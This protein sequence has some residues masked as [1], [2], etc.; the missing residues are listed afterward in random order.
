MN[1]DTVIIIA[2]SAIL[3][4]KETRPYQNLSLNYSVYLN[5]LLYS[6]WLEI[7]KDISE[8]YEI[9]ALLSEIDREFLPKYFIPPEIQ[10]IFYKETPLKNLTDFLIK[11][12]SVVNSKTLVLFYNSIGIKQSDISRVFNLNQS[13]ESSLIIGR[14]VRGDIVFACTYGLDKD[15]FDPLLIINRKY[16]EYLSL[17]SSK[18]IFI[19]TLDNFLSIDDFEDI[20][21]LYIELSKKESLSYCSQNMH[22]SFNDLFIEYKVLLN[23]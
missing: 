14:S 8:Q 16:D 11:Q 7:F 4:P 9:I 12:S 21:K 6:N 22:E 23:V 5:T 1:K 2:A 15:I 20:K 19:H 3:N 18:D 10:Q 17:I 13:E